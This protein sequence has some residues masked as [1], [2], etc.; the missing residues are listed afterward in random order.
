VVCACVVTMLATA[1]TPPEHILVP[2]GFM[3][4]GLGFGSRSRVR[5]FEI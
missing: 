3:V 1:A 2:D 5:T 4:C